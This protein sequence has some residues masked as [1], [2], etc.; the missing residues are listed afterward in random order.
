MSEYEMHRRAEGSTQY[1]I[2]L[3][4]AT[5]PLERILPVARLAGERDAANVLELIALL[6]DDEPVVRWWATLGLV[7]L[8]QHARPAESSLV[9]RLQ[10]E[11]P[12]VRVAAAEALLPLGRVDRSRATLVEALSHATPFV[13]LRAMNVLYHMGDAARPALPAIRQA[14]LEGIFPADYLNRMVQYV[15]EKLNR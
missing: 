7:M 3:S 14:S 5:Y 9:K 13:R 8:G 12:L 2:G 15:P 10:D 1:E 6:E 11:S 4:A